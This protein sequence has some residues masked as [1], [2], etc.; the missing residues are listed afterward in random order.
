MCVIVWLCQNM[1]STLVLEPLNY[2]GSFVAVSSDSYGD[3]V[4]PSFIDICSYMQKSHR[5]IQYIHIPVVCL[6]VWHYT[7]DSLPTGVA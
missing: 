6:P 4:V 3:T 7:Y 2:I 1:T 5:P